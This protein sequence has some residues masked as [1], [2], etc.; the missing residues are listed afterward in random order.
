MRGNAYAERW[1]RTARGEV[2]DP[3]AVRIRRRKFLG[4][5]LHEY[6]RSA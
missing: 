5:L 4:G 3:A 2:T 1:V 6:E